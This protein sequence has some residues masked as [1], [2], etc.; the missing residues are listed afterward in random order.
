MVRVRQPVAELTFLKPAKMLQHQKAMHQPPKAMHQPPKAMHQ[1]LKAM[2][3]PLKAMHQPLKAKS[4]LLSNSADD[5]NRHKTQKD[6]AVT[7]TA[8]S[9]FRC[10]SGLFRLECVS[11]RLW[12]PSRS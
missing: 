5:F 9:F 12:G 4:Q 11:A 6:V 2:H 3:Q 1:P 7:F 8:T 10:V